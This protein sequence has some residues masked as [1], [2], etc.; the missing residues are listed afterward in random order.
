[1]RYQDKNVLV[2]SVSQKAF[3]SLL[4]PS[5]GQKEPIPVCFLLE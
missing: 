2:E 1:M 3:S 4:S 5:R